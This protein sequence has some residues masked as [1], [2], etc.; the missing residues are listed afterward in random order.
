MAQI[1]GKQIAD[2]SIV[3]AKIDLTDSFDFTSGTVSVAT[4]TANSDAASKAYVDSISTGSAAGLD[5]KESVVVASAAN[6]AASYAANVLTASANGAISIDGVSLALNDRVLLKD[7]TTASDNGIYYVSTVGDGST[8]AEL[9]RATDADS[10]A[11]LNT[12]AF[13]FVEDGSTNQNRAYVLQANGDGS[14]PTL[15]TDDLV[16]I[17]FSGA[18]QI[19][20]G[21]GLS[22]SADTLNLDINGLTAV[23]DAA[24]SGDSIAVYDASVSGPRKISALTFLSDLTSSDEFA[25]VANKIALNLKSNGG[26][27]SSASGLELD[28]GNMSAVLSGALASTHSFVMVDSSGVRRIARDE[29]LAALAGDGLTADTVNGTLDASV[30]RLDSGSPGSNLST[31]GAATGITIS[32]EPLD[33]SAVLVLING[34]GI[35]LGDG[36]KTTEAYFSGDAGTTARALADIASGDQLI[37]NGATHYT[38]E[39]DDIVEIRFNA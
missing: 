5:F 4:P 3:A 9:T 2:A 23:A 8:A 19:T 17:Q 33:D 1:K 32:A 13:V 39:T 31:D 16:F 12:G 20:A 36:V 27:A 7:Q 28:D 26:L 22:K 15:D 10:S 37:W 24:A 6:F 18:G 14:S 35:E 30:P 38:L 34:V 29:L 25:S 21:D 11:D